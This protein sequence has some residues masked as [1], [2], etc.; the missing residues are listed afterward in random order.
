MA[1]LSEAPEAIVFELKEPFRVIERLL[2]PSRDDRL[3]AGK[4]HSDMALSVDLARSWSARCDA[5]IKSPARRRAFL[6][7][8]DRHSEPF[9]GK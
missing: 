4:C 1:C 9:C 5:P 2:S 3:Y 8:V 6:C 7:P